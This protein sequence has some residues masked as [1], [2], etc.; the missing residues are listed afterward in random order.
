MPHAHN[1]NTA[2]NS[3]SARGSQ[4]AGNVIPLRVPDPAVYQDLKTLAAMMPEDLYRQI[5]T[6]RWG[7]NG[8][9]HSL[10][11]IAEVTGCSLGTVR[12]R[13][14]MCLWNCHRIAQ[15]QELPAIRRLLGPDRSQWASRAWAQA[16]RWDE[17]TSRMAETRLLLAIGGMDVL[18]LDQIVGEQA[19]QAGA[20][21][22]NPWGAPLTRLERS[23][24]A[25]PVIDRILEHTIWP[26]TSRTPWEPGIFETKRMLNTKWS[27]AVNSGYFHSQKLDRMVMYESLLEHEMLLHLDADDRVIELIEQPLTIPAVVG[28]RE[29]LYTPDIAVKLADGRVVVIEV[30]GPQWLAEFGQWMRWTALARLCQLNGWGMYVGACGT[31]SIIDHYL[32]SRQ[33]PY[34]D[35][36]RTLAAAG[37]VAGTDNYHA[38]KAENPV[39]IAQAVTSELLAWAPGPK[40]GITIPAGV[41]LERARSFWHLI[42]T[43]AERLQRAEQPLFGAI[44][45][46]AVSVR[47]GGSEAL[48]SCEVPEDHPTGGSGDSLVSA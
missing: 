3:D 41:D 19:V 36:V 7:L 43:H 39:Q 45:R 37:A 32:A 44:D 31:R 46:S 47:D 9:V 4:H 20:L 48:R 29:H 40:G 34:R 15:H 25:R 18:Q 26:G 22:V 33:S 2:A 35:L 1:Q 21:S 12:G 38:L 27:G 11:E 6:L 8:P 24:I 16:A 5:F 28:D 23:E 17:I 42:A 13:L 14:G 30:K 10:A